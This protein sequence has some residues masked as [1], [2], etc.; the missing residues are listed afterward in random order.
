[1]KGME[2][3]IRNDADWRVTTVL[4]VPGG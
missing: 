1:M 2:T 4:A 3:R